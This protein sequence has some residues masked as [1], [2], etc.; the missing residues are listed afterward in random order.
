MYVTIAK[1]NWY[2][3]GDLQGTCATWRN[4]VLTATHIVQVQLI[5]QLISKA[6]VISTEV[7]K[8]MIVVQE[9]DAQI[10]KENPQNLDIKIIMAV[11]ILFTTLLVVHLAKETER[12]DLVDLVERVAHQVQVVRLELVVRQVKMEAQELVVLQ[13]LVVLVEMMVRVEHLERQVVLVLQ[14]PLEQMVT[15]VV[16]VLIILLQ[17]LLIQEQTQEQEK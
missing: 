13:G 8:W 9:M 17:L 6:V 11:V 10:I 5:L 14:E 12:V 7:A 16:H 2:K 1:K 3:F 4:H 15:L